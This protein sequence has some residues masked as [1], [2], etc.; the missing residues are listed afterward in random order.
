MHIGKYELQSPVINGGGLV[1]TVEDVR[2]M[3]RTSVG[4]VMPGSYT[5]DQ[6]IG[7][8]P[9]GEVTYYHDEH[10]GVTYNSRGLPNPG[11]EYVAEN[12]SEMASICHDYG[13]PLILNFAPVTSRPRIEV[14]AMAGMLVRGGV[15]YVDAIELNASCPNVVT[16]D[17]GRHELLCHDTAH[18]WEVLGDL[19]D[20]TRQY[21]P[22]GSLIVRIS[23][24]R[25]KQEV[26]D[27]A[28]VVGEMEIDAV[29][30]FNTFP[31]GIPTDSSGRP[32]LQVPGHAGGKSG[33]GMRQKAEKQTRW[34]A[35]A[36]DSGNYTFN[37]IGSNGIASGESMASR[38]AL[39]AAAVSATTAFW[40]ARSWGDAA[41][42]LL[43]E[44]AESLEQDG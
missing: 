27:V 26:K 17:G 18:L 6:R 23:P 3:A 10:S 25:S 33:P 41:N 20:I 4:A 12:F 19:R 14:R 28:R 24:F 39:G 44:Y 5:L 38:L 35:E 40:E 22:V 30:A 43:M 13:K 32:I 16:E 36:R 21:L 34:L 11:M 7:N 1:K 9:N 37:I 31:G 2:Q 15:E 8:S 42:R 29:A